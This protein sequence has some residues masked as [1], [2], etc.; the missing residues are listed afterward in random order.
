MLLKF[1]FLPLKPTEALME[2]GP[3]VYPCT[4]SLHSSLTGG[5]TGRSVDAW[6]NSAVVRST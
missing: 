5:T 4:F 6:K 1:I 2:V 3:N